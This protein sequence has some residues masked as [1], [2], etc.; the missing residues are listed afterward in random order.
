MAEKYYDECGG[1]AKCPGT[2]TKF[3]D[4][5][6]EVDMRIEKNR[7]Q[8]FVKWPKPFISV[9]EL[10]NDGFF[11]TGH[12]DIAKCEFCKVQL[13]NWEDN[14]IPNKEHKKFSPTCPMAVRGHP[15]N[16]PY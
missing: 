14:D 11:F 1:T 15:K 12:L 2:F 6:V 5:P 7:I 16:V 3:Y 8:S 10:A 4:Q 13:G 9:R